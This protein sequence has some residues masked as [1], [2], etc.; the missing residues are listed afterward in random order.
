VPMH[1]GTFWLS[2]EPLE[3]PLPRLLASAEKMGLADRIAVIREG[4]TRMFSKDTPSLEED[5]EEGKNR[6]HQLK[7]ERPRSSPWPPEGLKTHS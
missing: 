7:P 6:E 3:E 1:Y 4:E 2:A 5:R